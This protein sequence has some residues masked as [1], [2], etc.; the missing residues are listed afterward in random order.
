MFKN[1]HSP[2]KWQLSSFTCFKFHTHTL[3]PCTFFL[4]Q[5]HSPSPTFTSLPL[6]SWPCCAWTFP[7]RHPQ[8]CPSPFTL[9]C[10]SYPALHSLIIPDH[11][12]PFL[13]HAY[14]S[15]ALPS[16]PVPCI[17]LLT[18]PPWNSTPLFFWNSFNLPFPACS[19]Q[20]TPGLH[21]PPVFQ[22]PG[23]GS[24]EEVMCK[25]THL[26]W[27]LCSGTCPCMS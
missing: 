11:S 21:I 22:E 26:S 17:D 3:E 27:Q 14:P 6:F 5:L 1:V 2:C 7:Q 24:P 12:F 4:S 19:S 8:C 20:D 15:F 9:P 16:N 18:Y 23:R 13:T 10:L 25:H